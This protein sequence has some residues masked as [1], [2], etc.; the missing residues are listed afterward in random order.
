MNPSSFEFWL[1]DLI[2]HE[3]AKKASPPPWI[4]WC[5]P[6]REWV[7]LLRVAAQ[8]GPFEL[9]A[10]DSPSAPQ[11][12]LVLRDR[13]YREPPAPRVVWL[14]CAR[15]EVS[16]LK[17]YELH[18]T[19]VW[20]TS[21]VTAL[22]TYGVEIRPSDEADLAPL[23]PAHARE[24]FGHSLSIWRELT[25]AN[26]KGTLVDD[27]RMLEALAG[28][29]G[30]FARLKK[31]DRFSIFARRASE[32][33]G[34]LVP[35]LEGEA[36]WRID[37]L[38]RLLATEAA[39]ENPMSP[40]PEGDRII[41]AGW[42]RD[43]ALRLLRNW[44][45]NVYFIPTF[46]KLA[47]EA[48]GLLGL[49]WWAR[50]LSTP[51]RSKSSKVV[52]SVLLEQLVER[53]GQIENV[54]T[55][56]M[57]MESVGAIVSDRESGFWG[58]DASVGNRVPWTQL[59][60]L[61]TMAGLLVELDD[62]DKRWKTPTQAID[63]Y[64]EHGWKVD[65]AGERLFTED[66]GIPS[67]IQVLR[68]RLR[69]AYLR[70]M[71]HI[72]R[73]FSDL[74]EKRPDDLRTLPSA[75]DSILDDVEKRKGPLVLVVLD[76]FRF[77]L[78]RRL[79]EILN[80]GEPIRRAEVRRA[81]APIPSITAIGKAFALPI[82]QASFRCSLPEGAKGFRM[83]IDG[84]TGDLAIKDQRR[85]WLSEKLGAHA[86]HAMNDVIEG[87]VEKVNPRSKRIIVVEGDEFDTE[88]HDGQLELEGADVQL[89]RYATAIRRLRDTGYSRVLVVTDHGYFHWQPEKDEVECEKPVGKAAW[90]SRRA[91][92]GTDIAHR[93]ALSLSVPGSDLVALVP[94]SVN[95]WKTYGS[96]GFFH[97]GATLQELV[98]PTVIVTWPAK[99][100]K[101]GVVLKPVENI[102]SRNP[103]FEVQA[104]YVLLATEGHVARRV[105]VLVEDTSG[106]C[107]FQ[108][109]EPVTIEPGY[110][111]PRG[112]QL[113]LA[114]NHPTPA[115]NDTLVLLLRDADDSELLE[116]KNV[117]LK[118]D[119][120]DFE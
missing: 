55:L 69:K 63:W 18:A 26:A 24:W 74:L 104:A 30:A 59:A 20:E 25:P 9:W 98:I 67:S 113:K 14:P 79:A 22:R 93:T 75:G 29:P 107:V 41:P 11:H 71:D 38:S 90:T 13:L 95:A 65:A 118:V 5:D 1:L 7:E 47:P 68:I 108:L 10:P 91:F 40:P 109:A 92:V 2:R 62:I 60:P 73:R 61:C 27:D 39:H 16:W 4:L 52:E 112:V 105:T 51:P 50:N 87:R 56:A 94:R 64:A 120:D 46:E 101:V 88:G 86:F 53:L 82:A 97:G 99:A 6:N 58:R 37:A 23:L 89:Q 42:C 110:H 115:F 21:L 81:I 114:D 32:D 35:G 70:V 28:P 119:I 31:E 84:F 3:L 83:E 15:S 12:E 48:D 80:E 54:D 33:F 36:A 76:A 77:E 116:R 66:S 96:L 117:T 49:S 78:G 103:R 102:T 100:Q 106:R 72:G 57:E 44:K 111:E 34:L 8:D 85:K 45:S 17:V 19:L 43:R